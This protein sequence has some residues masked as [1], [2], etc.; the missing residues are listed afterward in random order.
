MSCIFKT[1]NFHQT[2]YPGWKHSFIHFRLPIIILYIIKYIGP[3]LILNNRFFLNN[4]IYLFI[5]TT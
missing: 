1:I 3:I 4:S 5:F 2:K